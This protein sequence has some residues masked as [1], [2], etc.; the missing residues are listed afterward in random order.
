MAAAADQPWWQEVPA[1]TT[2]QQVWAEQYI[3]VNGRLSWREVKD[4][5]SPAE[6]LASLYDPEARYSTK[7]A[8]EWVGSKVHLTE[9]CET[10]TP[11]DGQCRDDARHLTG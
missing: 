6:R 9:T 5:P 11:C 3:E 2:L 4:L 7:R 1:V 10:D 8:V